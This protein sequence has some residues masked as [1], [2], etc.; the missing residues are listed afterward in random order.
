METLLDN[1]TSNRSDWDGWLMGQPLMKPGRDLAVQSRDQTL[2]FS[3]ALN[4]LEGV[5][6]SLGRDLEAPLQDLR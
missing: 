4:T 6:I 2:P 1:L 3:L 5:P